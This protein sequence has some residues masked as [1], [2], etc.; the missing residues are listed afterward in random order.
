MLWIIS[1]SEYQ[2]YTKMKMK[3]YQVLVATGLCLYIFSLFTPILSIQEFYIFEE[4]ITIV[5]TLFI[6]LNNQ[7]WLLYVV[8]LLFTIILPISKY[9]LLLV[10]SID[11]YRMS[12]STRTLVFLEGISKWAML[13][14]F[15]I[16]IFVASIK[17]KMLAAAE[18][19]F[20][21]YLFVASIVVSIICTQILNSI[22]KSEKQNI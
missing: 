12:T 3:I 20:G 19:K 21:L 4:E 13:D 17:L 5:S 18:T 22:Q 1:H 10:Y 15:I 11:K 7:E 16:A 14:V 8:I 9:V 2:L 6:L